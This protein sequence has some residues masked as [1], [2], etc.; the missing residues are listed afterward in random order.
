ML[1]QIVDGAGSGAEVSVTMQDQA[2][3]PAAPSVTINEP[4]PRRGRRPKAN[5]TSEDAPPP[6][7]VADVSGD[8]TPDDEAEDLGLPTEGTMTYQ[9]AFDKALGG[10]AS[11]FNA[12][13][14]DPVYA[15]RKSYSVGKFNE[16]DPAKDGHRLYKDVQTMMEKVGMHI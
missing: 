8:G 7:E 9:E 3:K 14:K 4:S 11:T 12:G 13:H 15:L 16:L 6:V 1:D 2:D 10:I 5:G